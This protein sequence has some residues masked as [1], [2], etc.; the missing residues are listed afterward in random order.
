MI[1]IITCTRI[2]TSDSHP[3]KKQ[4]A[5]I[6]LIVLGFTGDVLLGAHGL[7]YG[8]G[9]AWVDRGGDG[10]RQPEQQGGV[11]RVWGPVIL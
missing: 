2:S 7:F 10:G 1:Y 6:A 8:P 3:I 11:V 4:I 5:L 9:P